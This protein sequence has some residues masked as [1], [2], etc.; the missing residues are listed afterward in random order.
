M[1]SEVKFVM[2]IWLVLYSHFCY[3]MAVWEMLILHHHWGRITR[4][5]Q[6]FTIGTQRRVI[7]MRLLTGIRVNQ[8]YKELE[9]IL[10]RK[11]AFLP[12]HTRPELFLTPRFKRKAQPVHGRKLKY[13]AKSRE[14]RYNF[15]NIR[16]TIGWQINKIDKSH[17]DNYVKIQLQW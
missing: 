14:P 2:I 12:W 5:Q 17:Q 6:L 1:H 11:S 4:W 15:K 7:N 9:N 8:V 16:F 10:E 3:L 13:A